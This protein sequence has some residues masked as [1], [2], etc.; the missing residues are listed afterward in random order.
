M[1][2]DT[3]FCHQCQGNNLKVIA[4]T[5]DPERPEKGNLCEFCLRGE[6]HPAMPK[7]MCAH[8]LGQACHVE[9]ANDYPHEFCV[10]H[11]PERAARV[12]ARLIATKKPLRLPRARLKYIN[13]S[14]EPLHTFAIEGKNYGFVG[15]PPLPPKKPIGAVK[16]GVETLDHIWHS[17]APEKKAALIDRLP[18]VSNA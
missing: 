11:L 5:P 14:A 18:E 10:T 8:R 13:T 12:A 1:T 16:V 7:R 4:T 9:L 15:R 3:K 17:L 2:R 6:R